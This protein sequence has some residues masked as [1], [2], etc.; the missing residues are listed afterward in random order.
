MRSRGE[1]EIVL[2]GN[3]SWRPYALQGVEGPD[4]DD[5]DD[6]RPKRLKFVRLF[7]YL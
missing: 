7:E 3:S 4:D 1:L 6:D 2:T 5:D